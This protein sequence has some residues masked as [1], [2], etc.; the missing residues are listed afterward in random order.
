MNLDLINL[1]KWRKPQLKIFTNKIIAKIDP[2]KCISCHLCYI[3]CEDGAHQSI[4]LVKDSRI[5]VIKE[6]T[7]VGCNLCS[8]VCPVENC[9]TMVNVS[10]KKEKLL[11]ADHPQNPN[12]VNVKISLKK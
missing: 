12:N 1:M 7:C 11:W 5:P 9:I 2:D 6:D 10:T 3:A 4:A 8:L